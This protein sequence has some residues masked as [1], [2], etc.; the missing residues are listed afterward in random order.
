MSGSEIGDLKT[1]IGNLSGE[2]SEIEK[3][4]IEERDLL[5]SQD[6]L[7]MK[8]FDQTHNIT[9]KPDDESDK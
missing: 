9:E 7:E 4:I 8:V 6:D 1:I 5:F 3:N 2:K